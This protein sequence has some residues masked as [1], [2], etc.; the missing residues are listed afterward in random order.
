MDDLKTHPT[1][2][3]GGSNT[4]KHELIA[5]EIFWATL[6]KYVMDHSN[7]DPHY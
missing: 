6:L 7:D 3:E 2:K 4:H 1:V 5:Q